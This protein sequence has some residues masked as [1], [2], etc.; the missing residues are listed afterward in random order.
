MKAIFPFES[1]CINRSRGFTLVELMIVMVVIGLLTA[2]GYPSYTAYLDRSKRAE[3]KAFL[4]ETAHRMER[5]YSDCNKYPLRLGTANNCTTNTINAP[6]KSPN[7]HYRV[8]VTQ[9]AG[10][11]FPNFTLSGR[12]NNWTDN[13]CRVLTLDSQGERGRRGTG[14][15][16]AEECWGK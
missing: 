7:G 10:L 3:G 4:L 2:I 16:T 8:F 5:F 11:G 1:I 14:G 12:P 6:S 13:D 9:N 15:K